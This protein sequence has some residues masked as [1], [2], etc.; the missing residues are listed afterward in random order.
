M[1]RPES[2]PDHELIAWLEP[3]QLVATSSLPLPRMQLSRRRDVAFWALRIF[4]LLTTGLVVY[5][6][7][8]SLG[9]K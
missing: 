1:H 8:A 7:I 2:H 9:G 6:F 5:V 4:V 3:D